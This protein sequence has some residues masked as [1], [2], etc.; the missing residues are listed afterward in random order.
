MKGTKE[1]S[2]ILISKINWVLLSPSKFIQHLPK[3]ILIGT[4]RSLIGY[5]IT[6]SNLTPK[7]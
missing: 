4:S 1:E 3:P 6:V 5:L 2:Y 7:L